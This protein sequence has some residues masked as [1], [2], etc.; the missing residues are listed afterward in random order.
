MSHYRGKFLASEQA[1]WA[2]QQREKLHASFV[3]HV[4]ALAQCIEEA[5]LQTAI[6]RYQQLLEIDPLVESA[7]QGLIRCY[8]A[9]GRVAEAQACHER[10]AALFEQPISA[11]SHVHDH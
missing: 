7:Y 3:R 9:Q 1:S 4:T 11:P 2:I 8:Q 10:C 6:F 5:D